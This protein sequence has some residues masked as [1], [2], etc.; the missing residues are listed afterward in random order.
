MGKNG[1]PLRLKMDG[2]DI[3][4]E[5]RERVLKH[6]TDITYNRFVKLDVTIH[7]SLANV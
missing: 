4:S 2:L 5:R 3:E 7:K 1:S 6:A